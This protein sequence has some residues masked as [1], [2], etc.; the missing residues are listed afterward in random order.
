MIGVSDFVSKVWFTI[1]KP[2]TRDTKPGIHYGREPSA[3]A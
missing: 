2:D 1:P 3:L